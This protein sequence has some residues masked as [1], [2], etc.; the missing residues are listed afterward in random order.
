MEWIQSLQSQHTINSTTHHNPERLAD[1]TF[2]RVYN[3]NETTNILYE[4]SIKG[5]V[6][7]VVGG[8]HGSVFAYGQVSSVYMC[9]FLYFTY[10]THTH[11]MCC[12]HTQHRRTVVKR[13]Q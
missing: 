4:E 11:I 3:E 8:Y 7:S 1:Y 2:D 9:W 6:K 10:F 12:F 5:V 13:I